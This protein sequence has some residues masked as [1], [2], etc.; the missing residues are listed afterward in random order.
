[1]LSDQQ[2]DYLMIVCGL[3]IQ[4]MSKLGHV[5]I[6]GFHKGGDLR[7]EFPPPADSIHLV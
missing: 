5:L 4:F 1:M 7:E 2:C 3:W 6:S